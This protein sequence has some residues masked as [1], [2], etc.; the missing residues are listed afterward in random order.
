[1]SDQLLH[2]ISFVRKS[3][4]WS[5]KLL[6]HMFNLVILN[7]YIINKHN[8]CEKLIHDEY[9]DKIVKYLLAEGLKN[10]NIPLVGELGNIIKMKMTAKDCVNGI[11]LLV[12]PRGRAEK[13]RN[14][15]SVVLFVVKYLGRY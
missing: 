1:M 2:Y 4:K 14:L 6:I 8:G 7:A 9:R 15:Q 10:Y 5:R 11:C 12:S 3:T 13:G